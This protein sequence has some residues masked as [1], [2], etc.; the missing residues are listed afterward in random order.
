MRHEC[1]MRR[2][3]LLWM[4][5][6]GLTCQGQQLMDGWFHRSDRA[7]ADQPHW[8][9]PLVTITPRLE[10]E[11]RTDFVGEKTSSASELINFGNSKGLELIPGERVEV[12]VNVPPYLEHNRAGIHDGF[13]DVSFLGKYRVFSGTED[14]GN[15]IM[16]LFL[17]ASIPTGSYENGARGGVITP[18]IAF[19]KGW[20]NFDVQ[21]TVGVGLPTSHANT[22]GHAITFNTAFQYR[23]WKLWPELEVNSTFWKDGIQD[24]K[25]QTFLTPGLILGRFKVHGRL[26]MALGSGFQIA[27]THYH[28]YNHA[29]L[30]TIRFPF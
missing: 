17:A 9:T 29:W 26:F 21:S 11:F 20:R 1:T 27:A 2:I 28:T 6:V 10:Q 30:I 12:I 14:S 16:T 8:M 4:I 18:T 5:F 19:G 22:I 25:K 13:G 15:Y 23:V 3:A 7:K 24:G